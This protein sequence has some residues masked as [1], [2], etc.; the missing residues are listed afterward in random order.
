[1]TTKQDVLK[2]IERM[3][4]DVSIDQIMYALHFRQHVDE[5]LRQADDES[6]LIPHDEIVREMNEWVQS[7]GLDSRGA[8]S[9]R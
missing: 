4:D 7:L 2:M 6:M 5:G 9:A 1:M 8:T 3:P